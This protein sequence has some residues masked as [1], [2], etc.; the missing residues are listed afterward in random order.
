[1]TFGDFSKKEN[2]ASRYMNQSPDRSNY[3]ELTAR[4]CKGQILK[5]AYFILFIYSYHWKSAYILWESDV[6]R[7]SLYTID[8]PEYQTYLE[9]V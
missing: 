5:T 1:M 9:I 8:H 7:K 4:W 2:E 6:S 3:E